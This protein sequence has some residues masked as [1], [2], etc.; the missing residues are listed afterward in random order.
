MTKNGKQGYVYVICDPQNEGLFK[1]GVTRGSIERRMKALQTG[2]PDEIFLAKCFETDDP[3]FLE[4]QL[5]LRYR[6]YHVN[7]EWYDLN[8]ER[9]SKFADYCRQI[10]EMRES[11]KDNPFFN[12]KSKR[13]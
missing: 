13:G 1:I 6:D 3:Y 4:K 8:T 11:L 9:L 12:K 7:G 5:H 2:N 10:E